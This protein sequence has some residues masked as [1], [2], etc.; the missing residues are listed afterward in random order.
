MLASKFDFNAACMFLSVGKNFCHFSVT[1]NAS[2]M[3]T[4]MMMRGALS[5]KQLSPIQG[6]LSRRLLPTTFHIAQLQN[7]NLPKRSFSFY[8]Q[9]LLKSDG[10]L[11]E[12]VCQPEAA[13][14]VGAKVKQAGK[15]V[16]N[17]GVI[18]VGFA[19]T[20]A[21]IWYC[22]SELMFSF[23]A[24]SVYSEAFKIIKDDR[25][26]AAIV[27]DGLKA[28]G[29]ETSRGRRR[30]VNYQEFIVDGINHMR[31]QFY[32]QSKEQKATVHCE[33]KETSRGNFEFRYIFVELHSYTPSKPIVVLDNR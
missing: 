2:N 3:S 16:S 24:N 27:G 18:V 1:G 12:E 19:I 21:L 28:Y 23:S 30:H 7:N 5:V 8:N 13:L 25:R 17:L 10:Q 14:T 20:G 4:F 11:S 29:E 22:V 32:I 26:V 6:L 15:D 31:V 9:I 33:A